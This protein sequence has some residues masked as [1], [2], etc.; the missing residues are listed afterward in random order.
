M[1]AA[2][3]NTTSARATQ[4]ESVKRMLV[5]MGATESQSNT[6]SLGE[7]KP[8]CGDPARDAGR[9]TAQRHALRR[10]ILTDMTTPALRATP[11]HSR[12]EVPF[13]RGRE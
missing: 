1:S 2:A 13:V 8:R 12:R 4:A 9:R 5:L 11:P 10:G 6:V 7:E 3:A